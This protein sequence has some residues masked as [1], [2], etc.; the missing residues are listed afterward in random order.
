MSRGGGILARGALT[1]A[2]FA[3][4][5]ARLRADGERVLLALDGADN[6]PAELGCDRE[7]VAA[8]GGWTLQ[9]ISS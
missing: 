2:G 4:R 8:D 9:P 3:D 6:D 1:D 5:V 7:L